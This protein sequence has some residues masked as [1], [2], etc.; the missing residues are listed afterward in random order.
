MHDKLSILSSSVKIRKEIF[1]ISKDGY[2]KNKIIFHYEIQKVMF[3]MKKMVNKERNK[4]KYK[5][6]R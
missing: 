3:R 5:N 2:E 6:K 4:N 1:L